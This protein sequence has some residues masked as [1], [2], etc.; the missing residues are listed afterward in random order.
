MLDLAESTGYLPPLL[1]LDCFGVSRKTVRLKVVDKYLPTL[2][3]G[4]SY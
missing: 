1:S 3:K 4:G 2:Q